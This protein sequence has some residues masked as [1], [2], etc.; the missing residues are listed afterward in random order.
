MV[1]I[2]HMYALGFV[3]SYTHTHM[4][5]HIQTYAHTENKTR[6]TQHDT[7]TKLVGRIGDVTNW[8]DTLTRT[9]TDTEKEIEKVSYCTCSIHYRYKSVQ[10]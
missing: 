9:L 10:Y 6:W 8:K 4:H 7:D 2:V 3:G 1:A 5:A